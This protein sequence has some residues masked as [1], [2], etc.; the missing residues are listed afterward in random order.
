MGTASY[1]SPEQARGVE[2]DAR[3]DIWSLGVVLYEMVASRTPFEGASATDVLAAILN[4]EPQPLARYQRGV[5]E[6]LEWI[7]TKALTKDREGRYQTAKELLTDLRRLKQRLEFEA[8]MERSVSP[9]SVS[10]LAGDQTAAILVASVPSSAAQ[11]VS[12][13]TPVETVTSETASRTSEVSSKHPTTSAEYLVQGIKQHKTGAIIFSILAIAVLGGLAFAAYKFFNSKKA[14]VPFQ[15]MKVTKLTTTGKVTLAAISPEGKYVVHVI[16]EVGKQ[17]L[18]MRQV[19]TTSN[20]QIVPPAE[21]TYRGLAF[22]PDGNFLYFTMYDNNTPIGYIYKVPVLGG[23]PQ[24][25]VEDVDSPATLSPDGK[26]FAYVRNYPREGEQGLFIANADGTGERRLATLKRPEGFRWGTG[27]GPAWSPDGKVIACGVWED[28][29]G[30]PYNTVLGVSVADGAIKPITTQ[31]WES[32]GQVAWLGDGNGLIVIA[33]EQSS[34]SLGQIWSI[35]YPGGEVRRIT[36]DLNDYRSMSLTADSRALVTVQSET[37]GNLWV[38]PNGDAASAR[39]ITS[40]NRDGIGISWTPDGRIVYGSAVNGKPDIWIANADGSNQK[41]LTTDPG[42]DNFPT[43][44]SDGRYILFES[45]RGDASGRSHIWRMDIDGGQPKQLTNGFVEFSP[46]CSP[47]ASWVVYVAGSP[48]QQILQK[49]P[50]D[51]G[52][53]VRLTEPGLIFEVAFVSPDGKLIDC[54]IND[55][56]ARKY[57][58][59]IMPSEGGQMIKFFDVPRSVALNATGV[60]WSPDSR[61][62][63]YIDT[64]DGVSNLW[65]QPVDGG[66]PKQLTDVKSDLIFDFAWSRDGKQLALVRGTRTNDAVLVNDLR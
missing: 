32:V 40:S 65:A 38:A 18:W 66:Q 53:P 61:A 12:A 3:T 20:V 21:A 42:V 26:Q 56:D 64:R 48:G 49:I 28:E 47:D 37:T 41:Q 54:I 23:T 44:T 63:V 5:P 35:S 39:K 8:E 17:S 34:N 2:V 15:N 16:D 13:Q 30:V 58:L 29:S 1:M 22:S 50:I 4:K 19:A 43:V 46:S 59:A 62:L 45:N 24:R 11:T 7:V 33:R 9:E 36:N 60:Y 14:I 10:S 6:A 31:K 25:L 51:G 55:L 57:R 27:V 52:E